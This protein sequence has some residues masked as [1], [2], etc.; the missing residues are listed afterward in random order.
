MGKPIRIGLDIG[1]TLTKIAIQNDSAPQGMDFQLDTARTDKR[2]TV[3]DAEEL[4]CWLTDTIRNKDGGYVVGVTGV[5]ADQCLAV[6]QRYRE[7]RMAPPDGDP[8]TRELRT[9]VAGIRSLA[10][11]Q[12]APLPDAFVVVGTGT[13]TSYTFV[14]GES[15]RQYMPGNSI[16]GGTLLRYGGS[17]EELQSDDASTFDDHSDIEMGDVFPHLQGTMLA[18][19]VMSSGGK[20]GGNDQASVS[21]LVMTQVARDILSFGHMPEWQLKGP[22]VPVGSPIEA[23]PVFRHHLEKTLRK[24]Q[25]GFGIQYRIIESASFAGAVGA[26]EFAKT[27]M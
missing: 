22:V 19:F 15:I 4:I 12:D 26:Y 25:E 23:F 3:T 27:K 20:L 1:G 17:I 5:G 24:M 8:V 9:Q 10:R 6:A 21:K 11:L 13:G 18:E 16:G 14:D 2:F 7:I